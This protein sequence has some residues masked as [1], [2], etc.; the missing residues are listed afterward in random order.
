MTFFNKKQDVID[1]QLTSEGR[2]QL[3]KGTFQPVYYE[4]YDD[5]I[6][7]DL[8]YASGEEGQNETEMRIKSQTVS[9]RGN[10]RF[11]SASMQSTT[12]FTKAGKKVLENDKK[13]QYEFGNVYFNPLGTFNSINQ[14]APYLELNVLNNKRYALSTSSYQPLP[15]AG[16]RIPQINV[17]CSYDYYYLRNKSGPGIQDVAYRHDD[18]LVLSIVEHNTI[19]ENFKDNFEV[20]VYEMTG[21]SYETL[22]QPKKFILPDQTKPMT[23]AANLKETLEVLELEDKIVNSISDCVVVLFDEIYENDLG[24]KFISHSK[25]IKGD[26]IDAPSVDPS[27]KS[28]V[29][30]ED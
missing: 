16:Q 9:N 1:F 6:I 22:S 23:P 17:T 18:P 29:D 7:Y 28:K 20:S 30:C 8:A 27:Q 5:D 11:V 2:L 15:G 19:L 21:S 4:F 14:F 25:L 24:V 10:V 3:S 26:G 12:K 13:N